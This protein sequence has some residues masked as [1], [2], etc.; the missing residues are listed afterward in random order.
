M[1]RGL[2][3]SK[4]Q[5]TGI[6]RVLERYTDLKRLAKGEV[7]VVHTTSPDWGEAFEVAGAVVTEVGSK[8]CHAAVVAREYGIPC[9]VNV[10]GAMGTIEDGASVRVDGL[11]GTVE[12]LE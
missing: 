1:L 10:K 8:L 7:L 2:G 4:G 12:V 3:A 9:V 6:A 5:Y 11:E